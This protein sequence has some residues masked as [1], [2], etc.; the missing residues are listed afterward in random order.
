[1]GKINGDRDKWGQAPFLGNGEFWRG[2]ASS[3]VKRHSYLER[4]LALNFI[5][6]FERPIRLKIHQTKNP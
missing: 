3:G 2:Q 5:E 6:G 1:M 4:G